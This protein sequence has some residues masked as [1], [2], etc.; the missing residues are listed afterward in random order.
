MANARLKDIADEVGISISA[1]SQV[2][3]NKTG[4]VRV[5]QKTRSRIFEVAKKLN[6]EP[7]AAA[8]SLVTGKSFNIGFLLYAKTTMGLANEYYASILCGLQSMC[9]KRGYGCQISIYDLSS[10]DAFLMPPKLRQRTV[11]AVVIT[12]YA[13]KKV[14][15]KLSEYKLPFMMIGESI[16][17]PLSDILVGA[18]DHSVKFSKIFEYLYSIGHRKIGCGSVYVEDR[19]EKL[20]NYLSQIQ[21]DKKDLNFQIYKGD[22]DSNEFDFAKKCADDWLKLPINERP[23]AVV[24][25][26]QFCIGFLTHLLRHDI[27]CPEEI[28]I[29]STSE[30][31]MCENF[32]PKIT[33]LNQF[34]YE[35]TFNSSG[36]FIDYVEKKIKW[37]EAHKKIENSWF[38][39]ELCIRESSGPPP[40][41]H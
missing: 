34:T 22:Y 36:I 3:R 15:E 5:P 26:P 4:I 28:T 18:A 6:Y 32:I 33:T 7:Q 9:F 1:V 39:N 30:N 2:L 35:N 10:I 16:D 40:S 25:N 41:R 13:E 20:K 27:K 11:D 14:I 38:K 37:E 24:E 8:R 23:T 29:I 21:E 17:F 31:A 19:F 12:G